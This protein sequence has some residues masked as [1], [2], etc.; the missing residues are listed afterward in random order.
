MVTL[1]MPS[2]GMVALALCQA[3]LLLALAPLATGF[4]RLIRARMHSRQGAGLLQDYRDILKLLGRQS[5]MPHSAGLIFRIT[6]S[7]LLVTLLLIAMSLPI[8]TCASPFPVSGDLIT[9]IY[10]LAI[11]RFFFSLA[12][13]DSG[14]IFA[15]I[16]ARRELT[17]GILVEP[18]LM[19]SGFVMAMMAGSSDIGNI[20]AYVASGHL[21]TPL[22]LLLAGCACGFALFVEMGKLPFDCAEAE[23]EL[24]EGP[25]CEYSGPGLAM[26]K[27]AM[28]LKQLVVALL[29]LALFLPFG[30]A[31]TWQPA[32]LL[33]AAALLLVKLGVVFLL[34]GVIENSMARTRFVNTS[35]LTRYGLVLAAMALLALLCGL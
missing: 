2:P 24:Q 4:N 31:L 22:A 25:L 32:A 29:F 9:L 6:P 10:L 11:F 23:Q 14:S 15:G 18:I 26:L 17:L 13:L 27:L 34:A 1:S 12:G 20:G 21:S 7:V 35:R 19:L 16:G 8:F 28:G 33:G 5:L 3:L 30:R